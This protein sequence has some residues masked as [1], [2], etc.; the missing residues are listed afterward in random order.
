LIQAKNLSTTRFDPCARPIKGY[1][2]QRSEKAFVNTLAE[3]YIQ[4]VSTRKVKA[5]TEELCGHAFNGQCDER[6]ATGTNS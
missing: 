4:G 6:P 3:M 2:Y 1:N 5:V